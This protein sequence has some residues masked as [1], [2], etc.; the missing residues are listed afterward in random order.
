MSARGWALFA[1]VSLLWGVPYLFIRIALEGLGPI[2]VVGARVLLAALILLPIA[3]RRGLAS[4]LRR[5]YRAL[6]LLA[7]PRPPVCWGW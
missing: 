5:R 4:L 1:A 7:R 2:A 3:H 6:A